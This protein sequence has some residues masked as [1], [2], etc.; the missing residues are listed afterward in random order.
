MEW[1]IDEAGPINMLLLNHGV[2]VALELEKMEL[3]EVKFT[4]DMNI[5]KSL[6]IVS[7]D[8]CE[9]LKAAKAANPRWC[10]GTCRDSDA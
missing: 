5:L 3:S 7:G 1:T 2:F 6:T 4:M 8:I 9:W 10:R